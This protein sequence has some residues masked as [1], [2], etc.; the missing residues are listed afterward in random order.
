MVVQ[1]GKVEGRGDVLTAYGTKMPVMLSIF[2]SLFASLLYVVTT[3]H[4]IGILPDSVA[5]MRIGT[6]RHFAPLY[7]WLLEAAAFVGIE[8]TTAAWLLNWLLY[9]VNTLLLLVVLVTARLG[10]VVAALGTLLIT[11][12]PVFVEFH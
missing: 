7:T 10:L 4:G 3:S 9:V 11:C 1:L 5:Y 12:H 6:A 2:L 8:I